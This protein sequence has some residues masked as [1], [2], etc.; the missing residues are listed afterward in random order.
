MEN[1][2]PVACFGYGLPESRRALRHRLAVAALCGWNNVPHDNAVMA[3][4]WQKCCEEPGA[5]PTKEAWL[6]V[7]DAVLKELEK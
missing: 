4:E 2:S 1:K 7:V 6:R 3:A 5:Q